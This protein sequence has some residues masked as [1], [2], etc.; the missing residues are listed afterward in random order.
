M[1]P[2]AVE[3]NGDLKSFV[4]A[5]N[6]W[7]TPNLTAIATHGLP[8]GAGRKGGVPKHKRRSAVPIQSR[9]VRP[10]L[11]NTETDGESSLQTEQ[12]VG[13]LDL[14][15]SQ[16]AVPTSSGFPAIAQSHFT[17]QSL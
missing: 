1:F 9:S 5:V 3:C 8:K 13:S 2:S 7:C 10:C 4:G 6:G 16:A 17:L 15:P 12:S 14:Q 11:L